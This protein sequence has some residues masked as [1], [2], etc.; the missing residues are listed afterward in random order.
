MSP[1]FRNMGLAQRLIDRVLDHVDEHRK[2][3]F[4]ISKVVLFMN[5]VQRVAKKIYERN[6]FEKTKSWQLP[7]LLGFSHTSLCFYEKKIGS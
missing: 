5:A 4:V 3:S 1:A 6:G 7:V 2:K